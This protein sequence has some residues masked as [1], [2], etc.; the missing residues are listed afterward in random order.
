MPISIVK[1]LSEL[2]PALAKQIQVEIK[3]IL[4][5]KNDSYYNQLAL[6]K[7]FRNTFILSEG[8]PAFISTFKKWAGADLI[9]KA[10]ENFG[11]LPSDNEQAYYMAENFPS[12]MLYNGENFS[13]TWEFLHFLGKNGQLKEYNYLLSFLYALPTKELLAWASWLSPSLNIYSKEKLIEFIYTYGRNFNY[14]VD[15]S[16]IETKISLQTI[17]KQSSPN[18]K[19]IAEISSSFFSFLR[20]WN[21]LEKTPYPSLIKYGI[22]LLTNDKNI[23]GINNKE[24]MNTTIH[25]ANEFA[26]LV[27]NAGQV[28]TADWA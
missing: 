22:I 10:L 23:V 19:R 14:K 6:E 9:K 15:Y 17:L 18:L 26:S 8:N 4:S 20:R 25:I 1:N 12:I 13:L 28:Q 7:Y 24:R 11:D 21:D 5:D 2:S 16:S 27:S 3:A